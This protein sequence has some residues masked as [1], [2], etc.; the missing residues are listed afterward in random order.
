MSAPSPVRAEVWTVDFSPGRGREQRG[1][2]PALI[3]QNDVG[4]RFAGTTIVAA[5]TTTVKIYPVTVPLDPGEGGLSRASMVNL[6]Q[7][8]TIDKARLRRRLGALSP[9][10]MRQVDAAVRV[11]LEIP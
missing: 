8:L 3:L 10:R 6:A 11:S 5:V 9:D 4:N 1:L 7:I 2:R